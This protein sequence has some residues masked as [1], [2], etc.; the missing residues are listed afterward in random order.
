MFQFD[1]NKHHFTYLARTSTNTFLHLTN[2]ISRRACDD[3]N[4]EQNFIKI[5]NIKT[6]EWDKRANKT[7]NKKFHT[8][9]QKSKMKKFTFKGVL[10]GFRQQVQPQMVKPEQ[11]IPETLRPEHFQ[12][13]KVSFDTFHIFISFVCPFRVY[14]VYVWIIIIGCLGRFETKTSIVMVREQHNNNNHSNNWPQTNRIYR[15]E[16]FKG[17]R[18]PYTFIFK[19]K[20]PFEYTIYGFVCVVS[21]GICNQHILSIEQCYVK[22]WQRSG[23][24]KP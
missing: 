23:S 2:K 1:A 12:L 19:N 16:K 17:T 6:K 9:K 13:K 20:F 4:K 3:K 21:T 5:W 10:D 18:T 24:I 7:T 8:Q 15:F 14:Y 11:E 22:T